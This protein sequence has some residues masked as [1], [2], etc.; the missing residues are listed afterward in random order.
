MIEKK[1]KILI[2]IFKKLEINILHQLLLN[3][4][5]S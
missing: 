1:I 5:T 4:E 3:F 2:Y